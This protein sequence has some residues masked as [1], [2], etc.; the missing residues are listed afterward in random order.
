MSIAIGLVEI[1]IIY[2]AISSVASYVINVHKEPD[3]LL[4]LGAA[5]VLV[6]TLKLYAVLFG[7]HLASSH[8]D[9][10]IENYNKIYTSLSVITII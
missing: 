9:R 5:I 1:F 8:T 3:A 10:T 7:Y 2:T 4:I 6:S